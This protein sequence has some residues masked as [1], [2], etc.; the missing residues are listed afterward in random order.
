[1]KTK[2]LED[3]LSVNQLAKKLNRYDFI[4]RYDEGGE[5]EAWI[6]AHSLSDIERSAWVLLDDCLPKLLSAESDEEVRDILLDIG[7]EFRH[8]LYH[9]KD[10]KFFRYLLE[11]SA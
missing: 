11:A 5:K 3:S 6:I 2:L 8:I 1:M 10:P 9:I 7:E 4:T